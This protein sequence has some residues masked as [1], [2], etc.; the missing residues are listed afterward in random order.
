MTSSIEEICEQLIQIQEQF[1]DNVELVEAITESEHAEDLLIAVG[2]A[3]AFK[4]G[5][6]TIDTK[7]EKHLQNSLEEIS[8]IAKEFVDSEGEDDDE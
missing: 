7:G 8:Q 6:I 1:E 3:I 2:M 4:Q 5:A